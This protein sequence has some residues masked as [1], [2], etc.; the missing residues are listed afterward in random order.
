MNTA[1]EIQLMVGLM[2]LGISFG[3]QAEWRPEEFPHPLTEFAKCGQPRP[4]YLCDPNNIVSKKYSDFIEY[5]LNRVPNVTSCPCSTWHCEHTTKPEGY[6]I[7]IAVMMKMRNDYDFDDKKDLAFNFAYGLESRRWDFGSCEND[8]IILYSEDDGII[9]TLAGSTAR[10][11]LSLAKAGEIQGALLHFFQP[12]GNV[13]QGLA[14]MVLNYIAVLRDEY[15]MPSWTV[16]GNG[17]ASIQ[18]VTVLPVAV[19]ALYRVFQFLLN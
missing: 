3:A 8:I 16:G 14:S 19:I 17:A 11:K 4:S 7:A 15:F 18:C 6:K 2:M 13:G 9:Y 1:L 10:E 12:G 5:H